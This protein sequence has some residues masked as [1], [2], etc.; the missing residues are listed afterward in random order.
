MAMRLV[1]EPLITRGLVLAAGVEALQGQVV[2]PSAAGA[3]LSD[4]EADGDNPAA[5]SHYWV[6]T[7]TDRPDAA[8]AGSVGVVGAPFVADIDVDGFVDAAAVAALA[9]GDNLVITTG[10]GAT[11]RLRELTADEEALDAIGDTPAN[12]GVV[13]H[14]ERVALN[15]FVRVK[16]NK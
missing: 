3:V 7:G 1:T 11:G 12:R 14:V 8:E 2:S 6:L 10:V 4:G 5:R 15:G 16:I 9:V 13:G